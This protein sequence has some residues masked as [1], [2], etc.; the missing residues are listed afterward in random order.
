[1]KKKPPDPP[2]AT[3]QTE[4]LPAAVKAVDR[5][6]E[7]VLEFIAE[8]SKKAP[9]AAEAVASENPAASESDGGEWM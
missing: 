4:A 7:V 3:N 1:M 9:L 8:D 6:A 2:R 5:D